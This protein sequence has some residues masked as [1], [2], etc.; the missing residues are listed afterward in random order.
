M[1]LT[2]NENYALRVNGGYFDGMKS[3]VPVE[4]AKLYSRKSARILNRV[5]MAGRGQVVRLSPAVL[6]TISAAQAANVSQL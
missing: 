1:K 6:G 5:I 3:G 2:Q 4:R